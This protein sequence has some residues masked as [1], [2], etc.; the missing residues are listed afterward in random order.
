MLPQD[1]D[2]IRESVTYGDREFGFITI[3]SQ[4]ILYDLA[5]GGRILAKFP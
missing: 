5:L 3:T 2:I 4:F 1:S